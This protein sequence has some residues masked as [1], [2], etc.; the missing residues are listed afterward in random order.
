LAA[1]GYL[2]AVYATLPYARTLWRHAEPLLGGRPTAAFLLAGAALAAALGVRA[3]TAGPARRV[4][5]LALLAAVLAAYGWL[6]AGF[7][8]GRLTIE[9]V[10]L[11]EYGLLAYLALNAV[12]VTPRGG[13]GAAVA[14]LFVAAAGAGDEALQR[15]IPNRVFDLY[16]VAANWLGGTLGAAAWTAASAASPWRRPAAEGAA[17]GS[18]S[19]SRRP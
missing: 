6:L 1:V 4:A 11:I 5:A 10:H 15:L 18:V 12:T 16:D 17:G 3:W 9:K 8:R 2:T 19:A 13:P 14:A 7:Y